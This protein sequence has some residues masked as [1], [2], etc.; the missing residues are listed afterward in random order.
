MFVVRGYET[1]SQLHE[2]E[3]S[4]IFRATREADGL[5][6]VLKVLKDVQPPPERIAR[7]KREYQIVK[8]LCLPGVASVHEILHTAGHWLFVEEDIGGESIARLG[9]C[10]KMDIG[11]LLS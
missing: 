9:I 4:L 2:S 10:G 3:Q 6:V 1:T 5:P 11:E 8:G 7:F